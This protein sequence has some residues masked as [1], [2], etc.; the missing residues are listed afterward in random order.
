MKLRFLISRHFSKCLLQLLLELLYRLVSKLCSC[1]SLLQLGCQSLDLFFIRLLTLIGFLF[2]NLQRLEAVGNDSQ[3]FF[4]LQDFGFSSICSFFSLFK[5]SI[6]LSQFLRYFFIS[7]ICCF[8]LV[9]CIF[10]FFFKGSNSFIVFNCFVLKDLFGTL[11]VISCCPSFVELCVSSNQLLFCLLKIFL[12]TLNSPIE[13]IH[14]CF[15]CKQRF[16]LLLKLEANNAKLFSSEIELSLQLSGLGC[17]F[18]NLILSFCGSYFGNFASLFA[19]ITS[20][21]GIVLLHLHGL[22]LLFDCIHL[23]A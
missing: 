2:S 14:L 1:L 22:H 20:V 12:K 10:Q 23:D 13:S 9:S 8:G 17:K 3:F 15:C 5:I 6:T 19:N 18:C 11:R 21:T 7:C 16:L 4:K